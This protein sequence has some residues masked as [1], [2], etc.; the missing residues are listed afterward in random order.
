MRTI[1]AQKLT[2]EA[3]PDVIEAME[4]LTGQAFPEVEVIDY[5]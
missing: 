1:K 2:A 3:F 5:E 4:A